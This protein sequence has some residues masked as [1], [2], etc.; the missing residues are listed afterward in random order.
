MNNFEYA[1][2]QNLP[3]LLDLLRSQS[4]KTELLVIDIFEAQSYGGKDA[5]G[6]W[7]DLLFHIVL[8]VQRL[9]H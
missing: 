2:P 5:V 7:A 9:V 8:I 6:Y 1:Q 4:E 3:E